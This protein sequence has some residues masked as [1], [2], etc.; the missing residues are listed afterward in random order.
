MILHIFDF[1]GKFQ[2]DKS[3]NRLIY[4]GI[5]LQGMMKI[6]YMLF[7]HYW[8]Y[9]LQHNLCIILMTSIKDNSINIDHSFWSQDLVYILLGKNLHMSFQ[10]ELKVL[11]KMLDLMIKY[12]H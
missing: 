3:Y 9:I 11:D 2:L 12:I 5:G 10:T 6:Q 4:I 8:V 1:V 7:G